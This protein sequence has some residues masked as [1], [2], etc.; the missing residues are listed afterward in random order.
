MLNVCGWY[1]NVPRRLLQ[2][3][4]EKYGI[5]LAKA[6]RS[7]PYFHWLP[8]LHKKPYGSR[9]IFASGGCST[10]IISKVLTACCGLNK[11]RQQGYYDAV[12]RNSGIQRYWLIKNPDEVSEV[13]SEV[14]RR[15][16]VSSIKTYDFSPLYT[17]FHTK[18]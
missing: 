16:Q 8:K 11:R 13:V 4:W 12:Y 3:V 1:H 14:N 2:K 17:I 9:F 7:L 15:G 6:Q 5:D 18:N 10:T